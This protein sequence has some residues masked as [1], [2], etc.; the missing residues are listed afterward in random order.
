MIVIELADEE[1]AQLA[2]GGDFKAFEE[3]ARR[4]SPPLYKFACGMLRNTEDASDV[5]QQVLIQVYKA[6]PRRNQR[7]P[8]RSWI[9]TIAR[10]KC[11]DQLRK[12]RVLTFS[13]LDDRHSREEEPDLLERLNDPTPLPEELVEQQATQEVLKEAIAH[14][15]E[16]Y[17]AVIALRYTSDLSF[18]EIGQVLNIPEGS[19]KTYFQRAKLWLRDYLKEK[20]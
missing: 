11:L 3:L 17:R 6:L 19:A 5:L 15:P 4:Y 9:F 18:S 7:A 13:E 8:F 2:A 12:R 16:R 10:N 1:L 20:L 14:L